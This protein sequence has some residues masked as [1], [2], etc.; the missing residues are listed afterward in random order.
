MM[1][2]PAHSSLTI[3]R[4]KITLYRYVFL[5]VAL[6]TITF[7][8]VVEAAANDGADNDVDPGSD[9]NG[10]MKEMDRREQQ[11]HAYESK[12]AAHEEWRQTTWS[13]FFVRQVQKVL[14]HLKPFI[15]LVLDAIKNNTNN[16]NNGNGGGEGSTITN[17]IM[18]IG[19]RM[20]VIIIFCIF[21]YMGG[22]VFQLIIGTNNNNNTNQNDNNSNIIEVV[23]EIVILHEYD[24]EEE[25]A[26]GRAITSRGKKQK[27][28]KIQ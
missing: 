20:S 10:Y 22:K 12:L 6:T 7:S 24:T 16:N 18:Y 14:N 11:E 15:V 21:G 2:I 8:I 19:V 26:K 3:D 27:Q 28:K 23:E 25:A 5:I 13:G 17:F 1:I 9:F 4:T